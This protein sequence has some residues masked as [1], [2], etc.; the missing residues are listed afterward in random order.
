LF[1][2]S[3]QFLKLPRFNIIGVIEGNRG[4]L[5][6]ELLLYV[7]SRKQQL[8]ASISTTAEAR[9]DLPLIDRLPPAVVGHQYD[10]FACAH[11][12]VG[13]VSTTLSENSQLDYLSLVA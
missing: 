10:L 1:D 13:V 11:L 3:L 7:G 4:Q 9:G 12:T 6:C 5:F 2:P 8:E